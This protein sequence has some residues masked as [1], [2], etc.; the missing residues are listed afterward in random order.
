M[1][2][3]AVSPPSGLLFSAGQDAT[4]RVWELNAAA[5]AFHLQATLSKDSGNGH[6]SAV[7]ALLVAG[8]F[9]F[10]ADRGGEVKVWSLT[11]GQCVQTI[12]RA[13]DGPIM[14]MLVWG[15]VRGPAGEGFGVAAAAFDIIIGAL[16][17]RLESDAF[18]S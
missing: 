9:L 6:H 15:E 7:H 4:I 3:L 10:S 17:G 12:E 1:L 14:K 5:G 13:H 11:D 16:S 8:Q 2:A 18:C